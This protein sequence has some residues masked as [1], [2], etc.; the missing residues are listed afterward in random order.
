MDTYQHV[1]NSISD[2]N[3]WSSFLANAKEFKTERMYVH[4]LFGQYHPVSTLAF[5]KVEIRMRPFQ[6][7]KHDL[8]YLNLLTFLK[9]N[10][11]LNKKRLISHTDIFSSSR[12]IITAWLTVYQPLHLQCINT[13]HWQSSNRLFIFHNLKKKKLYYV[14]W[15][16]SKRFEISTKLFMQKTGGL[17]C[18]RGTKLGSK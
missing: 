11:Q 13:T 16:R 5:Y 4:L 2:I 7:L 10:T 15:Q 3:Q 8:H 9:T 18:K 14:E 12:S 17:M 6:L 1:H